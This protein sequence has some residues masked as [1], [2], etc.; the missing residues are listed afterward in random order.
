MLPVDR[1]EK[2]PTPQVRDALERLV[3]SAG[4]GSYG[5]SEV[6]DGGEP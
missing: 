6:A 3:R 5:G 1:I 4:T 2:G